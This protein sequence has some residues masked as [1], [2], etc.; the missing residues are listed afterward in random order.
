MILVKLGH[1]ELFMLHAGVSWIMMVF[2][3]RGETAE[4]LNSDQ[5]SW[6]YGLLCIQYTVL[7][8]RAKT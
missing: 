8:F 1:L 7:F 5:V 6:V 3:W 4:V 2:V